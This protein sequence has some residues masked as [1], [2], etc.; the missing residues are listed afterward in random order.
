[1]KIKY[2]IKLRMDTLP[3]LRKISY[4]KKQ[5]K[6]HIL[7]TQKKRRH[8]IDE[9]IQSKSKKTQRKAAVKKK[10]RFNVLRIYRKTNYPEQCRR[11][12]QDM[13][14]MD[15]KY[16]L[17]TT[18]DICGKQKGGKSPQ[19]LFHPENPEKSFDVYIDKNKKDTIPIRFQTLQD[20]KNTIRKLETLYK[21]KKYSHK[22]IGQVAMILRVR[23][24]VVRKKK[25]KHYNLANRYTE[26]LKQRT[27]EKG[28]EKRKKLNFK[29]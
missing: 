28:F 25:P 3:K 5:H 11:I 23:L 20:V 22:R 4:A 10:A 12:T 17:G 29:I 15:K 16:K 18:R 6:Y 21:T 27:K 13:K 1:M 9:G 14:Y 2:C 26:F 8:A 24:K 7:D 19:F